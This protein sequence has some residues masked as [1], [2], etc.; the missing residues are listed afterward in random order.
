MVVAYYRFVLA[1]RIIS[2]PMRLTIGTL[3]VLDFD[4]RVIPRGSGGDVSSIRYQSGSGSTYSG[5]VTVE[6]NGET[7]LVTWTVAGGRQI[8]VGIGKDDLLAVS[9]RSGNAIGIA[10]YFLIKLVVG[11]ASGR[12]SAAKPWEPRFGPEAPENSSKRSFDLPRD[13]TR[14]HWR[15]PD[16][17]RRRPRGRHGA[18]AAAEG[19][20]SSTL[21]GWRRS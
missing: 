9:Y 11:R 10:L 15:H 20:A 4:C 1:G 3:L 19:P 21:T 18:L 6:R 2:Y 8:G 14:R 17:H 12:R 7:F 16:G 5:T 13:R